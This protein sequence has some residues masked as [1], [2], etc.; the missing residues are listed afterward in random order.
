MT[1]AYIF[2]GFVLGVPFGWVLLFLLAMC[3]QD[4]KRPPSKDEWKV[5]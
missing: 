4:V 2:I 3:G 1:A 5:M